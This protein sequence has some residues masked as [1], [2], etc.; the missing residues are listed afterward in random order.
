MRAL[1][2]LL[3]CVSIIAGSLDKKLYIFKVSTPLALLYLLSV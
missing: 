1:P 2:A 3:F